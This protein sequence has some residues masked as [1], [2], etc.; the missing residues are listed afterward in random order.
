MP[1]FKGSPYSI[2]KR[3]V[4][5]LIPVFGSQPAGD[6][7]VI[8][9]AVGCHYFPPGPQLPPQPLRGPVP[10]LLLGERRHNGYEQFAYDCYP[11][12]SRLRFEPGPFCACVQHANHSACICLQQCRLVQQRRLVP[13]KNI[14]PDSGGCSPP[15]PQLIRLCLARSRVV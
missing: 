10:I 1:V 11:I 12:A 6:V 3:R 2:T 14:L 4:P 8:N 5:K 15:A 13:E 9:P 7:R